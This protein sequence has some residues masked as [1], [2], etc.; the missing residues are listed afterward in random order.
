[1]CQTLKLGYDPMFLG[2]TIREIYQYIDI[3]NPNLAIFEDST[4]FPEHLVLDKDFT[5]LQANHHNEMLHFVKSHCSSI[6]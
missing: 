5:N 1:M 2:N 4:K 3:E 6:D